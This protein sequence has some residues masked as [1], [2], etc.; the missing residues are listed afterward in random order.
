MTQAIDTGMGLG[1]NSFPGKYTGCS[2]DRRFNSVALQKVNKVKF[3]IIV[4][5]KEGDCS[6]SEFLA[7]IL[8]LCPAELTVM[9]TFG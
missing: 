9:R 6:P 3:W 8:C 1:K 2:T 7:R 4:R 5:K